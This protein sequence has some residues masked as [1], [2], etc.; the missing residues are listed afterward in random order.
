MSTRKRTGGDVRDS[1][2]T[3]EDSHR[4]GTPRVEEISDMK[5]DE[6]NIAILFFLYVLQGIPLG[7]S[8]AIPMYLQNRGVSYRQQA[9]FSFV[10]WPFSVKLLWAPVVDSLFSA[11]FG[12]RKSWL[13]PAQYLIGFFMI[14]LSGKVEDWLGI[15]HSITHTPNIAILTFCFFCLNFLAATQDIAV[16]GWA[17]TMLQRRN[18]GHA[19]TC[20]SVG[21]TAGYFLGYVIFVG[22][23]SAE[24][25]NAYLRKDPLP[26]GIVTLPGFLYFWGI[27][28]LLSTTLIAVFKKEYSSTERLIEAEPYLGVAQTYRLLW[29]ITRLPSIR[30]TAII[31]LTSKVGF[32]ACDAVTSLKMIDAGFPKEKLALMAVP[33]VP[34]QI[35]L[36]LAISKYTV[37]PRPM[38]IYISAF[39]YRLLFSIVAAGLVWITPFVIQNGNIPIY[40]YV[41]L[42]LI[43][44]LHQVTLYS[45]FVAVMAFFARISDPA[46][47]GTYMTLLNTLSNL[48]G[49][50]PGTLALWMVD[51]LTFKQCSA[52]S[53]QN[54]TCITT[55]ET[56]ACLKAGGS[57]TTFVDGYFVET[58]LCT[59]IGWLWFQWGRRKINELQVK[60]HREWQVVQRREDEK[61]WHITIL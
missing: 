10:H 45:M 19:S 26:H 59:V 24:F 15:D 52:P 32:S 35:I 8:S 61:L 41:A 51:S 44:S 39:P 11:R 38:N 48:G 3:L 9:Q 7:L 20:N 6:W 14:F 34:L 25:C 58:T 42:I 12:R 55:Q 27:V 36:P 43:Y 16:D 53:I 1:S 40:Y 60:D 17:L 2:I 54:N 18:V 5:G 23:E 4:T 49:N 46:V 30:T 50:W 31:L 28:F 29:N 33:L 37:G 22:L 57:C 13:I 21:Q 47:G 56:E